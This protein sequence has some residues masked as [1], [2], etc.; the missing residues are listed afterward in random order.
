MTALILSPSEADPV[1]KER[2]GKRGL[3]R[4]RGPGGVKMILTLLT[5]MVAVHVRLPGVQLRE[6]GLERLF[7]RLRLG[8]SRGLNLGLQIGLHKL[9]E[10]LVGGGRSRSETRSGSVSGAEV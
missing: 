3:I 9:F 6:P 7:L 5:K 1:I 4:A 2:G 8:R 10:Q